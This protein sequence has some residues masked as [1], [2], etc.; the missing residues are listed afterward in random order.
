M[1]NPAV[2][3]AK[4]RNS[5]KSMDGIKPIRAQIR[6]VLR[7]LYDDIVYNSGFSEYSLTSLPYSTN[8]TIE[9]TTPGIP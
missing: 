4:M 9:H 6:P 5:K 7:L 3:I 8:A 1:E 2:T